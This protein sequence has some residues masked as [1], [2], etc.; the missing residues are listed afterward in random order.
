[1]TTF[2]DE[3]QE[4]KAQYPEERS[5]VL[6]AL[7]LAQERH[8]G[9]LPPEALQEVADALDLTAGAGRGGR[10]LL[11][12]APP[13]ARRQAPGRGV[14]QPLLRARRARSRCWRHSRASSASRPARRRRTGSSRCARSSAPVAAAGRS[15]SPSTTGTVQ[16]SSPR[17]SRRSWRRCAVGIDEIALAHAD[18]R[19][20]TQLAEYEAIG[21]YEALRKARGHGA[22]EDR[23][24]AHERRTCAAGAERAS[25]WAA[26]RASSPRAPA[27]RPTCA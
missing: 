24:G 15:S 14:H 4:I 20:L 8:G 3:V 5:A 19:D 16:P 18:E 23:R 1:M 10:V 2:Y 25:P 13:G 11:R 17:T 22:G 27:S 6:P 26:R 12:H 7:R 21:G 9:W